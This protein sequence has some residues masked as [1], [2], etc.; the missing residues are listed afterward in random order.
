MKKQY[1]ILLLGLILMI[2]FIIAEDT[3]YIYEYGKDIPL[4]INC[5]NETFGLCDSSTNCYI[6]VNYPDGT[7]LINNGTMNKVTSYYNYT[8]TSSLANQRGEYSATAYCDNGENGFSAFKFLL[9]TNNSRFPPYVLNLIITI[10]VLVLFYFGIMKE[11]ITLTAIASMGLIVIGIFTH[12]NGFGDVKNW[13]T[14]LWALINIA[15]GAY[16]L[17]RVT[18]EEAIGHLNGG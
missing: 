1:K 4:N 9:T 14:D 12:I 13:I 16:V 6:T 7:N 18:A 10:F 11:D 8:L 3:D 15:V 2:P 17:I 5:F